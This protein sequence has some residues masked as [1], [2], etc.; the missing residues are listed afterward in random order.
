MYDQKQ[1]D[2]LMAASGEL[3][4]YLIQM[5]APLEGDPGKPY[6]D[7]ASLSLASDAIKE[8]FGTIPHDYGAGKLTDAEIARMLPEFRGALKVV[9]VLVSKGAIFP[10]PIVH[11]IVV[12]VVRALC[13]A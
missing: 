13:R 5:R 3:N 6:G 10:T 11:Q 12:E 4:K 8:T 2:E 7:Q 1:H 9:K